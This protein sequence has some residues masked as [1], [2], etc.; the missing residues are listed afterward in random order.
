MLVDAPFL[1]SDAYRMLAELVDMDIDITDIY[2]S[3][4]HPDHFY[5]ANLVRQAFPRARFVARPSVAVDIVE[6]AAWKQTQWKSMFGD[7]LPAELPFPMPMDETTLDVEGV[8]LQVLDGWDGDVPGNTVVWEPRSGLFLG[9]D[10]VYDNVLV[11]TIRTTRESR[12]KW[13]ASLDRIE[14]MAPRIVIPGHHDPA[15]HTAFGMNSVAFTRRFLDVYD[16]ALASAT[17]GDELIT[18]VRS[19][20]PGV[21]RMDRFLQWNVAAMFPDASDWVERGPY[22]RAQA[23][24]EHAL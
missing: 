21:H 16:E 24:L 20:F 12:E 9:T 11:W 10:V 22:E 13:R 4:W 3:H 8:E 6:H 23:I 18:A 7:R 17:S 1:I 2:V 14:Q 19:A 5:T 15:L